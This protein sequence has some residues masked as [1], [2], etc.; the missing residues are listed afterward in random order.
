M[1]SLARAARHDILRRLAPPLRHDMV[2]HLQS[3]GMV[4][5]ALTARLDRGNVVA[6]DLHGMVSKLNRLSRQA[7][8]TCVEVSTWMQPGEDDAMSLRDGVSECVRLLSTSL[9]FRGFD[10]STQI[11]SGEFDVSRFALRFLL[12]AAIF[13]LTDAA[14]SP[15]EVTIRTELS[16]T[17]GV[18][19]VE[20]VPQ[21]NS[22]FAHVHDAT[23][24]PLA[25]NEVQALA[26]EESTELVRSGERIVMRLPRAVVTTP[27]KMAPV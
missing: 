8:A 22:G 15:G 14:T 18:I 17:H 25:W 5:E 16:P 23:D 7:V 27:L 12:P 21:P 6:E 4:A 20:Y 19:S 1:R 11:G 13:T 9:N 10:L 3:L 2:V 24:A 26:A